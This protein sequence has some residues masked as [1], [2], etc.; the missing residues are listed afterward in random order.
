MLFFY[1]Q[2]WASAL[3]S[4]GSLLLNIILLF[5]SNAVIIFSSF[6]LSQIVREGFKT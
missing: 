6:F 3:Y 2:F 4:T 5:G 1:K